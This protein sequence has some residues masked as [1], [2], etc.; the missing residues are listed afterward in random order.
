MALTSTLH[1][2]R[3]ALSDTD[4]G[5]YETFE[6][7][8]ARHPSETLPYMLT[9]VL[10]YCMFWDAGIAFSKG[11]STPDEPALWIRTLDGRVRLWIE[12]G[13]P[14]ADRLHKA[15]KTAERVV[16]C[17]SQDPRLL[18]RSIAGERIH[19]ADQIELVVFPAGLM[20]E[21]EAQVGKRMDWEVVVTGGQLYVTTPGGTSAGE[22]VRQPLVAG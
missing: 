9:R 15:S 8:V 22:L 18:L 6:L 5:V 4:R 12:I 10:A 11:L 7:R 16:V 13:R 19:R 1:H 17:T 3:I 21:L 2:I 14:G 20:G